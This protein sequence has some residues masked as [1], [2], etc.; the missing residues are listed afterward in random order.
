MEKMFSLFGD[1]QNCDTQLLRNIT[2]LVGSSFLEIA[3]SEEK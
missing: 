3:M 2:G 1:G